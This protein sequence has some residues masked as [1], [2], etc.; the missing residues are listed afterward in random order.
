MANRVL[1]LKEEEVYGVASATAPD[2][3]Q[4]IEKA[5][6]LLNSEPMT[7]SGGSR[8]IKK[9]KAGAINPEASYDMKADLKMIGHYFK[10]F[11]G[12]YRYT[13]GGAGPNIHEFWGG[14]NSVLPSFTGWS[15]FDIFMK[16]LFG[17]VCESLKLDVSDEFMDGSVEWKYKT[18]QKISEVPD[19]VDQKLIPDNPLIAF[20]DIKLE[21]DSAAPPGVVSTFSLEGKNNLNV[22]KIRGIGSRAPQIKPKAQ[23]REISISLESTL[24]AETIDLIEKAE[25]GAA[26]NEPSP[27]QLY[28]LPLKIII[29]FCEDST[30]KMTVFI[31]DCIFSVDYEASGADEID[32]KFEL[33]TLATKKVKL[34]DE[35]EEIT[36]IYVKLENDQP[37]ITYIEEGTSSVTF[38]LVTE[39]LD[40]LVGA[41]VKITHRQS[42]STFTGAAP[43]NSQ[44]E[45]VIIFAKFGS[46]DIEVTYGS[47]IE[48]I[49]PTRMLI[50][51]YTESVPVTVT[52]PPA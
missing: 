41:T 21:L 51:E 33:Q 6:A 26:G 52:L 48:K 45:C 47:P 49:T 38:T 46:Y 42:G 2:W 22:D 43:T 20:Y 50:N 8:S 28:K 24:V 4:E 32:V 18:E 5:K 31:P 9:A 10:A 16:Q 3:H 35:T 37:Q 29:D 36:D 15:T 40:P 30:D 12:N 14:E 19:P 44:G 13:G 34:A 17:M 11:L 23:R 25:Y 1:G 39:A 27:C 7:Y